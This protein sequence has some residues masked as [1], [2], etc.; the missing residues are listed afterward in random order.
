[1]QRRFTNESKV[2]WIHPE[3]TEKAT[4]S[5]CLPRSP[6]RSRRITIL[7]S[8]KCRER[9]SQQEFKKEKEQNQLMGMENVFDSF[10]FQKNGN[11]L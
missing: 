5:F 1:M 3:S 4:D 7:P 6:Q 9:E 8:I 11:R 10:A 2:V